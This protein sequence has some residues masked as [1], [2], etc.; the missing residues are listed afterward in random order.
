L[1]LQGAALC[2]VLN[3]ERIK[4]QAFGIPLGVSILRSE[5]LEMISPLATDL[6]EVASRVGDSWEH[7]RNARI[8]LTGG[9]GF[10]GKWLVDSF[11][12]ANDRRRLDARLVVLSRNAA[13]FRQAMPHLAERADIAYHAGDVRDFEFP[14]GPFT[15]VIHAATPSTAASGNQQTLWLIDTI[16]EGT[17]HTLDFARHSGSQRFLIT[18]SGAVYGPQP[19]ELTRMPETYLGS[20]PTSDLRASYGLAKRMAEHF[21]ALYGAESGMAVILARCFAFVGPHLPLDAHFAIGNFI[22]DGLAGKTIKIQG[23]GT[24][25]RSYLYAADLAAWLWTLLVKGASAQPYNVGSDAVVSIGQLA[26]EVADEFEPAPVVTIARTAVPG[27]VPLRYVPC[28]A[29]ARTELHLDAWT[30]RSEAIRRTIAH[31]RRTTSGNP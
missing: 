25:E 27:A 15:H 26:H 8:F 18:S 17:R 1:D 2:S 20:P 5:A 22:R 14:A 4:L 13:A 12:W 28:C 10:F 31:Q 16:V 21:C 9:T 30:S 23:D 29:R 24:P 6:E 11:A 3:A 19:P 7:L